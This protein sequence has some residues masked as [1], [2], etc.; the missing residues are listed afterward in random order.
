MSWR[1]ACTTTYLDIAAALRSTLLDMLSRFIPRPTEFLRVLTECHA[2][3]GGLF[4]LA[5][6][7]RNRGLTGRTIDVFTTRDWLPKLLEYLLY[8][9][10]ISDHITFQ[11]GVFT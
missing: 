9:P 6:V 11:T 7:L 4:A 8:S 1:A 10:F 3:I 5:F 2:L